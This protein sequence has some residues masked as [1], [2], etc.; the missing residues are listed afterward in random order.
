MN[1]HHKT[2]NTIGYQTLLK[3]C[4]LVL[5]SKY[6]ILLIFIF[7]SISKSKIVVAIIFIN[8]LRIT[9]LIKESYPIFD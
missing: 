9:F 3:I 5:L 8:S 2:S 4:E 1:Q 7:D 6:F